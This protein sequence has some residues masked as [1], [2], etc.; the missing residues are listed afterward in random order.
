MLP[1]GVSNLGMKN[2]GISFSR[3]VLMGLVVALLAGSSFTAEAK[4]KSN[5]NAH[6]LQQQKKKSAQHLLLQQQ[7]KKAATTATDKATKTLDQDPANA[8][9][10]K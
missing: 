3:K 6:L 1:A 5:S 10:P 4:P 7:K 2:L 8:V 9:K